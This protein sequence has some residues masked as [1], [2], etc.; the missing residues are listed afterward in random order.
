MLGAR[1][2]LQA[3][4]N[5]C[6]WF[7]GKSGCSGSADPT[8]DRPSL[9][10]SSAIGAVEPTLP[11]N[12]KPSSRWSCSAQHQISSYLCK[13]HPVVLDDSGVKKWKQMSNIITVWQTASPP[14]LLLLPPT[15]AEWC[16]M[17]IWAPSLMTSIQWDSSA[18]SDSVV[19]IPS[20]LFFFLVEEPPASSTDRPVSQEAWSS[21]RVLLPEARVLLPK[22]SVDGSSSARVSWS[23]GNFSV[24]FSEGRIWPAFRQSSIHSYFNATCTTITRTKTQHQFDQKHICYSIHHQEKQDPQQ[25]NSQ[26]HHHPLQI[27]ESTILSYIHANHKTSHEGRE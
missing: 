12:P 7:S 18:G 8:S 23:E 10:A 1:K 3:K 16:T 20:R 17:P 21:R 13:N 4:T 27:P 26:T 19:I 15:T 22:A 5:C 6:T 14:W 24:Y 25:T 11:I 2:N 9:V